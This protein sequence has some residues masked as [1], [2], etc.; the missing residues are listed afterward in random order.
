MGQHWLSS[1]LEARPR[2]N[3]THMT[4]PQRNLTET[5][6]APEYR[7]EGAFKVTGRARYAA[8]YQPPG[9]LIARYLKSPVP[10]ARIVSIDASAARAVPGVHAVLTGLD[11]GPRR[12]GKVLYDCPVLAY[13]RVRYVGERVAAV[14][15]ETAEAADEA[16]DLIVV[17]YEELPVVLDP[18]AALSS[19]APVLHPDAADYHY[20]LGERPA[21]PHPNLQ[22]HRVVEKGDSAAR[23]RAFAEAF[24]VV[25]SVYTTARQHQGYIEPHACLVWI[26]PNT[27]HIISTNKSAFS[28]QHQ[29]SVVTGVSE[30]QVVVEGAFIGGDFGG[31]GH[32]ID[33]YVCYFLAKATGRP[34]KSVMSYADELGAC[35]PRNSSRFELRTAVDAEGHILAHES[36]VYYDDGAYAAARPLPGPILEG[37]STLD[38]YN[39]PLARME[40]LLVYTNT[41]PGGQM[42]APGAMH[43]SFAGECHIDDVARA[44]KMDPLEFRLRNALGV[45]DTIPSGVKV[46]DPRGAALLETL[47]RETTWGQPLLPN[48]GRGL[49]LRSRHV[50]Q[51]KNGVLVRLLP[52]SRIEIVHGSPDQGGGAATMIQRVAAATLEIDP[53][54]IVVRYG[55]TAEAPYSPG[56]GASRTTHTLGQATIQGVLAFKEALEDAAAQ[57]LGA[58]SVQWQGD[59]FIVTAGGV[60]GEGESPTTVPLPSQ[61]EMLGEGAPASARSLPFTEVAAR[62]ASSS[63]VEAWGAYDSAEHHSHDGEDMNYCAYM[64]EVEVDPETGQ[65]TPIEAVLAVDVGTIINPLAFQGQLEGGFIFGLGNA[66]MEELILGEDG[67]VTNL[68]LGEYKLPTQKDVPKLRVIHVPTKIGPGPFGAKSVG[69]TANNAVAAAINNAVTDA[70]GVR[71]THMPLTAEA[72]LDALP[73]A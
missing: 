69:E 15:A 47:Q 43:T 34:I 58:R 63:P 22:G 35:N 25:E 23:E 67:R 26:E 13:D 53:D 55:S 10:H 64:I 49:S 29:L 70:T 36:R 5:F 4:A 68:N 33:E 52:D 3:P 61:W 42:R 28:L 56:A 41:V 57:S 19:D 73:N 32:S 14:A 6:R 62:L 48:R 44:L 12:Y 38:P 31:K 39:V 59:Q 7:V 11:L 37:W 16:L 46:R 9:T 8:D 27:V 65:V 18:R 2:Y 21:V 71:L 72:V 66:L 50:G 54:R 51:G 30:E 24:R 45:G 1:V 60:K 17:T 40:T 20:D